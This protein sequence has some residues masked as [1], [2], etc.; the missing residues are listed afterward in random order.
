M[1]KA[2]SAGALA[3]SLVWVGVAASGVA[4]QR[5]TRPDPY[6]NV[7]DAAEIFDRETRRQLTDVIDAIER[8]TRAQLAV[9]TAGDL[10]GQPLADRARRVYTERGLG[11]RGVDNGALILIAPATRDV[12]LEIGR[13]LRRVLNESVSAAI[14]DEMKTLV[15]DER[16]EEA[17]LRGARALSA[18]LQSRYTLS[19]E[20]LRILE[21][22][23]PDAGFYVVIVIVGIL[24]GASGLV[25]G[26]SAR[27][28]TAAA[29]LAG[30]SI[31]ILLILFS[32][33]LLPWSAAVLVPLFVVLA[34]VGFRRNYTAFN[35]RRDRRGRRVFNPSKWELGAP[36]FFRPSRPRDDLDPWP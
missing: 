14:V 26:V 4:A 25:A 19:P 2:A 18:I 35:F 5:R 34:V 13:G 24:A 15:L 22:L 11:L 10:A 36:I 3:L 7:I 28:K 9:A 23:G 20:E 21:E 30:V 8:E 17:A 12:H 1:V 29:M 27:N 31:G 32:V 33:L 16:F 6:P